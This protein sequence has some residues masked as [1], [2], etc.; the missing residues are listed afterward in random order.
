VVAACQANQTAVEC[1]L[2]S[3][4]DPTH[5]LLSYSLLELLR[6]RFRDSL[7]ESRWGDLWEPLR[8]QM[9]QR[10]A[11][12]HPLLLGPQE[13]HI[14]GGSSAPLELGLPL[15]VMAD[16]QLSLGAGQ[17]AGIGVGAR[18]ALYGPAEPALFPP[19]SSPQDLAARIGELQVISADAVSAVLTFVSGTSEALPQGARTRL[20]APG[21]E[22]RLRVFCA[23]QVA[24][25][26]AEALGAGTAFCRV[27]E[28]PQE[29]ELLLGQSES[30]EILF[31]DQIFSH[32]TPT[33]PGRPSPLARLPL[34]AAGDPR[35]ASDRR[36]TALL[37]AVEHY[38]RYVLPLRLCQQPGSVRPAGALE[39]ELIDCGNP[40]AVAVMKAD[41]SRRRRIAPGDDGACA[42][43]S[44]A[45]CCFYV[46]N[47]AWS[48]LYVT[49]LDCNSEG[50]V[51]LLAEPVH[52]DSFK[53][54]LIWDYSDNRAAPFAL[55]SEGRSLALDRVIAIGCTDPRMDV[56]SL[57]QVCPV[58]QVPTLQA[59]IDTALN[60]SGKAVLR[61][62][63]QVIEWTCAQLNLKIT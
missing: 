57:R 50:W 20:I 41:A 12:Q 46:H 5:G 16:G 44:G 10:V 61:R 40:Q 14:F 21:A 19:L 27:V 15:R 33:E 49:L 63:P 23:P 30:G 36:R 39:L 43:P 9:Q 3:D 6:G 42:V 62:N 47:S 1:N 11:G 55:S 26:V 29:A 31:G 54:A 53:G 38:S 32:A 59:L 48:G 4:S 2:P 8:A 13:H 18:L 35:I 56:R 22:D 51:D 24:P 7:A 37:I 17:L 34:K 28:N 25:W 58:N 45:E 60:S 52:I